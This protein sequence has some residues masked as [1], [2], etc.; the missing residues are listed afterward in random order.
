MQDLRARVAENRPV[1]YV[2]TRLG[3]LERGEIITAGQPFLIGAMGEFD[4]TPKLLLPSNAYITNYD[5][6]IAIGLVEAEYANQ[7]YFL[8]FN[9]AAYYAIVEGTSAEE[10]LA[11]ARDLRD[12]IATYLDG[13]DV[14]Y[15]AET[16]GDTKVYYTV[17]TYP[18]YFQITILNA[19]ANRHRVMLAATRSNA[20][21]VV[22]YIDL[23]GL[24]M[25]DFVV[26]P[27]L[28]K[29][30]T[31]VLSMIRERDEYFFTNVEFKDDAT[32]KEDFVFTP[33]KAVIRQDLSDYDKPFAPEKPGER[34]I[35]FLE[36]DPLDVYEYNAEDY[37]T[38]EE[39]ARQKELAQLYADS[40]VNSLAHRGYA[41][42]EKGAVSPNTRGVQTLT[43][44]LL[45][46]TVS[47]S[48]VLNEGAT[49]YNVLAAVTSDASN[50]SFY[51][52]IHSLDI[53]IGQKNIYAETELGGH[54]RDGLTHDDGI[55][56]QIWDDYLASHF[57]PLHEYK[58]EF[59]F[60]LAATVDDSIGGMIDL[61]DTLKQ[62]YL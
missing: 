62:F 8:E 7:I 17:E 38:P 44:E 28:R 1:D 4:G 46:M 26:H 48:V 33:T 19:G 23:T 54:L 60:N 24:S 11:Y 18:M 30:V 5:D 15:T 51:L 21:G 13:R 59:E 42:F 32:V 10:S 31:S 25:D 6:A 12:Q 39:L 14:D 16:I 56:Y 29:N 41:W 57:R 20:D 40:L 53:G 45:K 50:F 35:Y 58:W 52:K 55:T 36:F 9:P 34:E 22:P 27:A 47:I 43:D 37:A 2:V 61:S 49:G 3:V